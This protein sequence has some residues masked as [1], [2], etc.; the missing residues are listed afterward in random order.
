MF[1]PSLLNRRSF[2]PEF[3]QIFCSQHIF[4]LRVPWELQL[5]ECAQSSRWNHSQRVHTQISANSERFSTKQSNQIM[6]RNW[7]SV[8]NHDGWCYHTHRLVSAVTVRKA[9]LWMTLISF[10]LKSLWK[11]TTKCP[12]N[13]ENKHQ[14]LLHPLCVTECVWLNMFYW[15]CVTNKQRECVDSAFT[16]ESIDSAADP[17]FYHLGSALI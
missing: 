4:H 14:F 6:T 15:V 11:I 7:T 16:P 13:T 10:L 5:T 2:P 8:L 3:G 9:S 12:H 1:L 17:G